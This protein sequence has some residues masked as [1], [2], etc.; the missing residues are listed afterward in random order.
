VEAIEMQENGLTAIQESVETLIAPTSENL[1]AVLDQLV[2]EHGPERTAQVARIVF[3]SWRSRI[4]EVERVLNDILAQ[5]AS[6][7]P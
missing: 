5:G 1:R 2:R 6:P 7:N 3:G 4:D